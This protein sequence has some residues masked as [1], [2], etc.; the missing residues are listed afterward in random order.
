[1]KEVSFTSGKIT[2]LCEN[3]ARSVV[4]TTEK[5]FFFFGST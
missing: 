1:M 5:N 2:C 4:A 3:G